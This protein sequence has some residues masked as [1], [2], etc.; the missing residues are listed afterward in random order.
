VSQLV[1]GT[2]Q[3]SLHTNEF[4][5]SPNFCFVLVMQEDGRLVSSLST[6]I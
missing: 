4:L 3:S 5:Q 1:E 2:N 6:K